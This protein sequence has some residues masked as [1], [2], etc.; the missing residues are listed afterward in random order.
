MNEW[1]MAHPYLTFF[2][3]I[4]TL[5]SVT[6]VIS[7]ILKLFKK[8]EPPPNVHFNMDFPQPREEDDEGPPSRD[9]LN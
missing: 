2:L 1:S 4:F 7:D 5:L 6:S 9:N 8:P 3:S